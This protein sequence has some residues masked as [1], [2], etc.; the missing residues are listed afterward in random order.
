MNN[1]IT[2][3]QIFNSTINL[4]K[5][6]PNGWQVFE[7]ICESFILS[8]YDIDINLNNSDDDI[9]EFSYDIEGL[10]QEEIDAIATIL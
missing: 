5:S 7:N 9:E 3:T 8:T 4:I 2:P 10:S 6:H 1:N